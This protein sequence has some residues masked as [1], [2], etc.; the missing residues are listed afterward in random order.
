M[1]SSTS[2]SY[3]LTAVS[4]LFPSDADY[5][6]AIQLSET[7]ANF[8]KAHTGLGTSRDNSYLTI[9]ASAIDDTSSN[10][11]IAVLIR[12]ALQ[13][14]MFFPDNSTPFL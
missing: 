1:P 3:R 13:A 12:W 11:V 4:A 9:S 14:E 2:D 8:I 6:F 7:D 5:R 10:A